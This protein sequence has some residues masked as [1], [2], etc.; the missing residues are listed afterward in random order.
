MRER[1][2]VRERERERERDYNGKENRKIDRHGDPHAVDIRLVRQTHRLTDRPTERHKRNA[3]EA[4][5]FL[6]RK[7]LFLPSYLSADWRK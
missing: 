6:P 3:P 2:R 4:G 1:E 7:F 5:S